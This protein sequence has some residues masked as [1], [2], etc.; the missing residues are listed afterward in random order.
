[1]S[2]VIKVLQSHPVAT[3]KKRHWAWG[4]YKSQHHRYYHHPY[5]FIYLL[6][7]CHGCKVA[8][9]WAGSWPT[10]IISMSLSFFTYTILPRHPQCPHEAPTG[11][12]SSSVLPCN[13]HQF[14]SPSTWSFFRLVLLLPHHSLLPFPTYP[15]SIPQFFRWCT[16]LDQTAAIHH[17]ELVE[18]LYG[19]FDLFHKLQD[20]SDY[21]CSDTVGDSNGRW[22]RIATT[23]AAASAAVAFQVWT[24]LDIII[25]LSKLFNRFFT[26]WKW[27]VESV[28]ELHQPTQEVKEVVSIF[29]ALRWVLEFCYRYRNQM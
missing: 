15:V 9:S 14:W 13:C 23:A 29:R 26:D 4:S 6:G 3:E 20:P 19:L 27:H 17:K 16:S 28:G 1:M 25:S 22:S 8:N 18:F 2:E 7:W 21:Y 10:I 5:P 24:V 11:W 12:E